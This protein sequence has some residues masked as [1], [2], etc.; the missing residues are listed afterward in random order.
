MLDLGLG[1]SN[2]FVCL[3]QFLNVVDA[4][5]QGIMVDLS[6][7]D[8]QHVQDHLGILG[9]VFVPTVVQGFSRAGKR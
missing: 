5:T 7:V 2:G 4:S 9:I 8:P 1:V 6:R 3:R